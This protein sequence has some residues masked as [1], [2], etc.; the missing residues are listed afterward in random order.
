MHTVR[1]LNA[2][3]MPYLMREQFRVQVLVSNQGPFWETTIGHYPQREE[4]N[5]RA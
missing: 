4:T 1:D 5:P 3:G 2:H